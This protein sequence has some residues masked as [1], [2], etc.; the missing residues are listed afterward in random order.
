MR[1]AT[2]SSCQATIIWAETTHGKPMP[3]DAEP[4]ANGNVTL[5]ESQD[6]REPPLAV[7][8]RAGSGTHQA[9]FVTCPHAAEHRKAP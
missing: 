4:V 9:H 5:H 8:G 6:P 3:V 2:C 7:V 1:T